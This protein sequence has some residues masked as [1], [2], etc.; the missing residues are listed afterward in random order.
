MSTSAKQKREMPQRY[1]MEA[2]KCAK[3]GYIAFPPRSICP[4][5]HTREFEKFVLPDHGTVVTYTVIRVAPTQFTDEAPYAVAVVQLGETRL[6]CQIVDCDLDQLAIG[7]E[8][9]IEF[10]R[11]QSEGQAGILHYGYKAVPA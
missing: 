5:C 10:R 11:I 9:K 4:E 8:I 3:C 7:D 2:G 6:L 1:R